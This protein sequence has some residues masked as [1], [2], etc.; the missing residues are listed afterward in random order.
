M[1]LFGLIG[2]RIFVVLSLPLPVT[3]CHFLVI[4]VQC[5]FRLG[6]CTV[7]V[8]DLNETRISPISSGGAAQDYFVLR[9]PANHEVKL[10]ISQARLT[11][12]FCRGC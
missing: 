9:P 12:G 10:K 5:E 1:L 4:L 6:V 11:S 7:W 8:V 3:L 2:G